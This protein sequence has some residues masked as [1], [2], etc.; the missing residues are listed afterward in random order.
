MKLSLKSKLF[1]GL[2]V[3]P[4]EI[5][6]NTPTVVGVQ[7]DCEPTKSQRRRILYVNKWLGS[8]GKI[9]IRENVSGHT[10]VVFTGQMNDVSEAQRATL[11]LTQVVYRIIGIR[12]LIRKT[13]CGNPSVDR[14]L[15]E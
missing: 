4:K 6:P 2:A 3:F 13:P 12:S 11:F 8:T 10:I 9:R 1:P 15:M 14:V 7:L 5:T